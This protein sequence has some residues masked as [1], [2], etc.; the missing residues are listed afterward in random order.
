MRK[1][2]LHKMMWLSI[3]KRQ[4]HIWI[5]LNINIKLILGIK[6]LLNS[7]TNKKLTQSWIVHMSSL[8]K[9]SLFTYYNKRSTNQET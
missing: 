4:K 3:I 6:N 8:I 7:L 9:R 5:K 1:R 2:K